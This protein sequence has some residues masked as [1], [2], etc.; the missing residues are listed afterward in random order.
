MSYNNRITTKCDKCHKF[1]KVYQIALSNGKVIK[2]YCI[3][4]YNEHS[5]EVAPEN[6][7][8]GCK[9]DL[10]RCRLKTF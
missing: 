6:C 1:H 7:P 9:G 3:D 8:C 4:C 5:N 2:N 10:L